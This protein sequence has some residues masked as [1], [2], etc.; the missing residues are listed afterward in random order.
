MNNITYGLT[1]EH[2]SLHRRTRIS[3]GIA[4]YADADIDGSTTIVARVC[5]ITSDKIKLL[6]LVNKCNCM[7]LSLLHL[8]DVI[9]DFLAN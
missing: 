3:Y 7:K 8:D 2:Y 6:N 4:V 5:D 9:E 1:E